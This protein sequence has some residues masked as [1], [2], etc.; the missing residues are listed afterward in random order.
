MA[1]TSREAGGAGPNWNPDWETG[2]FGVS[3]ERYISQEF[4][5]LE[6]EKLWPHVWQWACREEEI[7]RPG[8]YTVY[9]IVDQEILVIR[10]A[11]G[12][13]KAY[14][15]VCPHR[16]TALAVGSGRFSTGEIT[17]PFHGWRWNLDGDNT[18]V[19]DRDEFKG[20]CLSDSDV[21]LRE[22]QVERWIGMVFIN[23]DKDAPSF[24]DHI[25]PVKEM[26]EGTGIGDME[27]RW[28]KKIISP[29]NWKKSQEAFHEAYHVMG[30]H[31]EL[32]KIFVGM[33][34]GM[35]DGRTAN[36]H[37]EALGNGHG[38]MGAPAGAQPSRV[39]NMQ[40]GQNNLTQEEMVDWFIKNH[41]WMATT[42]DAMQLEE[43]LYIVESM[44]NREIPEGSDFMTEFN[45]AIYGHYKNR[46]RKIASPEGLARV[47]DVLTFPNFTFL[48]TFGNALVYRARPLSNNDPDWHQFEFWSI[49]T[50]AEGETVPRP[51][52]EEADIHGI[53]FFLQQDFRNIPRMQ[54]GLHSHGFQDTLLSDRQEI[55]IRNLHLELDKY[56]KA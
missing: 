56:L 44:R 39:R 38:V 52:C 53:P 40:Q 51:K 20:G 9:E 37:Y 47:A 4:A 22:V 17:C 12:T 13:I 6:A 35:D 5:D 30:T 15:N 18:F 46:G 24:W 54:K 21:K 8:D 32:Y 7:P 10:T 19:L 3:K 16:A 11:D 2:E 26:I 27:I 43:D 25:A 45:K 28:W 36:S 1:T 23:M 42:I 34:G 41:H 14:H 31:P 29:G 33:S 49:R 55:M 50:Y 48:P